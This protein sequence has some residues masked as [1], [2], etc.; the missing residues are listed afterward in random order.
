MNN[1]KI[2]KDSYVNQLHINALNTIKNLYI[3][4]EVSLNRNYMLTSNNTIKLIS[5]NSIFNFNKTIF[6][7]INYYLK[8]KEDLMNIKLS[9]D[10]IESILNCNI[11]NNYLKSNTKAN[12]ENLYGYS[13]SKNIIEFIE[14]NNIYIASLI[15]YYKDFN[16]NE[17][18][19]LKNIIKINKNFEENNNI[20]LELHIKNMFDENSCFSII[21]N[22]HDLKKYRYTIFEL[23]LES[24]MYFDIKLNNINNYLLADKYKCIYSDNLDII[25]IYQNKLNHRLNNINL[26]KHAKLNKELSSNEFLI[27]RVFVELNLIEKEYYVNYSFKILNNNNY[28]Y[29]AETECIIESNKQNKDLNLGNDFTNSISTKNK[30]DKILYKLENN[31]LNYN[32]IK[33]KKRVYLNLNDLYKSEIEE[34]FSYLIQKEN[35]VYLFNTYNDYKKRKKEA[36]IIK[37]ENKNQL[38]IEMEEKK[39]KSIDEIEEIE[40]YIELNKKNFNKNEEIIL[41]EKNSESLLSNI[42]YVTSYDILKFRLYNFFILVLLIIITSFIIYESLNSYELNYIYKKNINLFVKKNLFNPKFSNLFYNKRDNTNYK[43]VQYVKSI[44]NNKY[45]LKDGYYLSELNIN[46]LIT[47]RNDLLIWTK[48]IFADLIFCRKSELNYVSSVFKNMNVNNYL[49]KDIDQDKLNN[50]FLKN[51]NYYKLIGSVKLSFIK[52]K[53]SKSNNYYSKYY[54]NLD[55]N[56]FFSFSNLIFNKLNYD[57]KDHIFYTNK[58]DINR[59]NSKEALMKLYSIEKYICEYN[60]ISNNL[61]RYNIAKY[62]SNYIGKFANYKGFGKYNFLIDSNYVDFDNFNSLI[63]YIKYSIYKNKNVRLISFDFNLLHT[64]LFCVTNVS[65]N[66]EFSS[67]G[68]IN[69]KVLINVLV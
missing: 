30:T 62:H 55:N 1:N 33:T 31:N 19:K 54:L 48:Y 34:Y 13:N 43:S 58:N 8:E 26:Y 53:N 9:N 16:K 69:S 11:L 64:Y 6:K 21:K 23:K 56:Y 37:K 17:S 63:D 25:N 20:L 36:Q 59:I 29:I 57:D 51:N 39:N 3:N 67:L 45:S 47:N 60:C 66:F 27:N 7:S 42:F 65:I 22:T 46:K 10:D 52:T 2:S 28:N 40:R 41:K 61:L 18:N 4:I 44:K 32:K 14:I 5:N 50:L 38:N 35:L 24:C 15:K 49:N 12:L 68:E